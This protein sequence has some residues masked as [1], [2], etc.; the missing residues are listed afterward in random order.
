MI[1]HVRALKCWI[2]QCNWEA[3]ISAAKKAHES[4]ILTDKFLEDQGFNVA[5]W[6]PDLQ[7]VLWR[8]YFKNATF[9]ILEA[10]KSAYLKIRH[11][12]PML[13]STMLLA[14]GIDWRID[15]TSRAGGAASGSRCD[16][17]R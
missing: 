9:A 8:E 3:V 10:I 11:P 13:Q 1:A 12:A 16:T 5:T 7:S 2:L 6:V 17:L 14:V 4:N 15:N